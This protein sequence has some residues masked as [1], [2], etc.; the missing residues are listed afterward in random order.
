MKPIEKKCFRLVQEIVCLR[1]RV[2]RRCG[3]TPISGHHLWSRRN[4][5]TAFE[6]DSML[7]LC[8]DCHARAHNNPKDCQALLREKIGEER[9][10]YLEALSRETVRLREPNFKAIALDLQSKLAEMRGK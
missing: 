5:S 1:D 6:P 3:A 2:C 8:L 9:Y 10:I 7:G 4:H